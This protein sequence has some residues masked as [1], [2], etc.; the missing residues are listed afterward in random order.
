MEKVFQGENISRAISPRDVQV[1]LAPK[2]EDPKNDSPQ[3]YGED[4]GEDNLA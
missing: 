1:S 3:D 2:D 4:S